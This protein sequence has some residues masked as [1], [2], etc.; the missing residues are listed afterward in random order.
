[1]LSRSYLSAPINTS[2]CYRAHGR[3]LE[4]EVIATRLAAA[5]GMNKPIEREAWPKK[6]LRIM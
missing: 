6:C 3:E 4:R 2:E 5:T 1:M